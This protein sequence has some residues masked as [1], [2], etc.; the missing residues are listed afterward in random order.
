MSIIKILL[1]I[2]LIFTLTGCGFKVINPSELNKFSISE[3]IT[4]GDYRINNIIKNKLTF[5]S[6]K[7]DEKLVTIK[8]NTSKNK[9]IKEKNIK[10]EI[11]KYQIQIIV[12]V[13]FKE[14]GKDIERQFT[15]TKTGDYGIGSQH[16][17]TLSNEK[18]LIK[19][20]T[21]NISDKILEELSSN[22]NDI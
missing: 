5:N 12:E 17:Q 22:L 7:N 11:T 18:N 15:L 16:S 20:L 13:K 2:F 6:N 14:A 21:S 10:N 4:K 3:I 9:Y 8:L 19:L 1:K